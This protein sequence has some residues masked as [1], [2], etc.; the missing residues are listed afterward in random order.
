M[1]KGKTRYNK[2]EPQLLKPQKLLKLFCHT[3]TIRAILDGLNSKSATF[4]VCSE[5]VLNVIFKT[6]LINKIKIDLNMW[7]KQ[8]IFIALSF[9]N[10]F[11]P[12]TEIRGSILLK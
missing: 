5:M 2:N 9:T 4:Y 7:A 10:K 6:K 11:C 12:K 1:A 3:T 8:T